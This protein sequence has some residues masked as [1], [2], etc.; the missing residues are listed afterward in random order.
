MF[1]AFR[2]PKREGDDWAKVDTVKSLSKSLFKW[3]IKRWLS[4]L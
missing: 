3:R 4:I 1:P 2:L